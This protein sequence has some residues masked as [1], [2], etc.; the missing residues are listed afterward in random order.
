MPETSA[1]PTASRNSPARTASD[2]TKTATTMKP[3]KTPSFTLGSSLLQEAVAPGEVVGIERMGERMGDAIGHP[4]RKLPG[5]G[6]TGQDVGLLCHGRPAPL[7]ARLSP[8][9]ARPISHDS[10]EKT[11]T[12]SPAPTTAERM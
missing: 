5:G 9:R 4:I 6:R 1:S 12:M 11:S 8:D 3:T 2:F 10:P 7:Q